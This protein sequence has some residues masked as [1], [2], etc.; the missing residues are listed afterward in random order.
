MRDDE[1]RRQILA[2][3]ARAHAF[4]D[5]M[6]ALQDRIVREGDSADLQAQMQEL[7]AAADDEQALLREL[8]ELQRRSIRRR[9]RFV[10][11]AML[12]SF[13][14]LVTLIIAELR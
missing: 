12:V 5:Q 14:G 4:V 11:V 6:V 9:L 10:V 2:S 3:D 7:L 8:A 1:L 13:A